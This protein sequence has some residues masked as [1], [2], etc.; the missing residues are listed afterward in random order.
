VRGV[1]VLSVARSGAVLVDSVRNAAS[2]VVLA[3]GGV[4]VDEPR[5]SKVVVTSVVVP[6]KAHSKM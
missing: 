6:H 1:V 4:A 2:E 5:C 3:A